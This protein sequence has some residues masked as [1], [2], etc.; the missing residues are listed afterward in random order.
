MDLSGTVALVTGGNGG[1]GQRICHA[2]AK[3]GVHI[4]VMYAQSRSMPAPQ[5]TPS[6]AINKG[7]RYR[8]Y[9][10]AALITEAGNRSRTKQTDRCPGARHTT[11]VLVQGRRRALSCRPPHSTEDS[12]IKQCRCFGT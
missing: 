9:V 12:S 6:H 11:R 4:A 3:E 7:R 1:L 10:S 8:Y 5:L 2:L